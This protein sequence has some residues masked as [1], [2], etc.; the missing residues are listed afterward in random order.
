MLPIL[1]REIVQTR[2]WATEEELMDYYAIGQCTPGVIAVNAATF[3]GYKRDG[4]RGA[5]AATAGVVFPSLLIIITIS[6]FIQQFALLPIVQH[7]FAGVRVVVCALVLHAVSGMVKKSV[8]D[9]PTALILLITFVA[10]AFANVSPIIAVVCS[11]AAGIT[12]G[13]LRRRKS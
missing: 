12:I 5:I 11:G 8:T 4:V 7:I 13:V 6:A 10:V 3:V 9:L 1:Q 2:G